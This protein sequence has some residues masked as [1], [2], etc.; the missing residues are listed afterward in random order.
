MLSDGIEQLYRC[1]KILTDEGAGSD[2]GNIG[3]VAMPNG[4]GGAM[5]PLWRQMVLL[6][7]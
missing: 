6:Q 2:V 7:H 1:A 5:A 3:V 4:E